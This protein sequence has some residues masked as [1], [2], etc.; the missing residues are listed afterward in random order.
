MRRIHSFKGFLVYLLTDPKFPD[1][2]RYVGKTTQSLHRRLTKHVQPSYLKEPSHKNNW[3]KTVLK[4]GRYPEI[5]ILETC[6]DLVSMN[7]AE[8]AWISYFRREGA[9]LTNMTE[10][11]DGFSP[12][13]KMPTAA[14][15]RI[16][17]ANTGQK[18]SPETRKKI[19]EAKRGIPVSEETRLKMSAGQRRSRGIV[20]TKP[21]SLPPSARWASRGIN[22][23]RAKGTRPIVDQ[24]GRQYETQA[25]VSRVHNIDG[26]SISLHLRGK[27]GTVHG[28]CLRYIDEAEDKKNV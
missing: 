26:G 19:S 24:H 7:E 18:K 16:R 5:K 17:K 9:P 25:E 10:G 4:H 20:E 28:L 13:H 21:P 6:C 27:L 22:I 1:V 8:Q 2:A 11:G 23:S 12:G 15:E 14:I 3:L